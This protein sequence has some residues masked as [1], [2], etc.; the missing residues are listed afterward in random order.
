[1]SPVNLKGSRPLRASHAEPAHGNRGSG[2]PKGGRERAQAAW[3]EAAQAGK[4][5]SGGGGWIKACVCHGA[6]ERVCRS[7]ASLWG[8]PSEAKRSPGHPIGDK[9]P[10]KAADPRGIKAPWQTRAPA[11]TTRNAPAKSRRPL[12]PGDAAP[13]ARAASNRGLAGADKNGG[14]SPTTALRA[15]PGGS[16]GE[17]GPRVRNR[18]RGQQA[19]RRVGATPPIGAMRQMQSRRRVF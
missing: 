15:K 13:M 5:V 12:Q 9:R 2:R 18:E 17:L 8:A 1:M 3:G 7:G 16:R 11:A 19:P 4:S 14:R 10:I 6:P